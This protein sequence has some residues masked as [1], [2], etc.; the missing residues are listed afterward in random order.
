V[1]A[2]TDPARPAPCPDQCRRRGHGHRDRLDRAPRSGEL[3]LSRLLAALAIVSWAALGATV[4]FELVLDR[5]HLRARAGDA[6]VLTA[7]AGTAV[8]AARI[9]PAGA[10]G[11]Q[12]A[13]GAAGALN[14][15]PLALAS[16]RRPAD[17]GCGP[18]GRPHPGAPR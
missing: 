10:H 5:G 11:A 16:R 1:A 14:W 2:A 9:G 8:V 17:G 4:A 15:P 7:V 12:A 18:G 6:G 3:L 13:L